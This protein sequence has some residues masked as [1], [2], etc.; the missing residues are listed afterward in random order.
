V[1]G[2]L[3]LRRRAH[4]HRHDQAQVVIDLAGNATDDY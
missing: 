2:H 1:L 4:D 3:L